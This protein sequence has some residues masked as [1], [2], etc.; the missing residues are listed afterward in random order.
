MRF[1]KLLYFIP[2]SIFISCGSF[3]SVTDT[4]LL[5]QGLDYYKEVYNTKPCD[6]D[7]AF[8]ESDTEYCKTY[9]DYDSTRLK[10]IDLLVT[11]GK[12]LEMFVE[13]N[14]FEPDEQIDLLMG[15]GN[16][17]GWMSLSDNQ[18]SGSKKIVNATFSLINNGIKRKTLKNVLRDNNNA[19]QMI[20]SSL[21]NDLKLR[22]LIYNNTLKKMNDYMNEDTDLDSDRREVL[23]NSETNVGFVKRNK[24]DVINIKLIKNRIYRDTVQIANSITALTAFGNAHDILAKNFDRIGTNSDP[25]LAKLIFSDLKNLYKGLNNLKREEE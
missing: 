16:S 17:A 21:K 20:V 15:S 3:E 23:D 11:Y 25:E 5:A 14:G 12:T 24:L 18:I 1:Y 10:T 4:G 9:E 7:A 8:N 2:F 13:D 22:N 19:V 6:I